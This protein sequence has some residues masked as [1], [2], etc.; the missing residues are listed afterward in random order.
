MHAKSK[1]ANYQDGAEITRIG[2]Y[3]VISN[4]TLTLSLRPA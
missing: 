3:Y 2:A 1:D 4:Q